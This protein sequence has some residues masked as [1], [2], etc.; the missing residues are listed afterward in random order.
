MTAQAS[1]AT[2][3]LLRAAPGR[4]RLVPEPH[5]E[6]PVWAYNSSIPGPEIRVRQGTRLR[7]HVENG[8]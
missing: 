6:T 3:V 4:A 2:E 5:P 1:P 8:L 7:V